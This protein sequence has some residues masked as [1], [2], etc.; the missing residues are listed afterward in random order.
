MPYARQDNLAG[1]ACGLTVAVTAAGGMNET[2]QPPEECCRRYRD[3]HLLLLLIAPSSCNPA[4]IDNHRASKD[5][6]FGDGLPLTVSRLISYVTHGKLKADH[7][8]IQCHVLYCTHG[9]Y[10]H[11]LALLI[12][13]VNVLNAGCTNVQNSDI[14]RTI[15]LLHRRTTVLVSL[16]NG[17]A[18]LLCERRMRYA[19]SIHVAH[20]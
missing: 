15:Y 3:R 2:E 6:S 5:S 8:H 20:W 11:A 18:D 10:V 14:G 13:R 7:L 19:R 12:N 9:L 1:C 17:R 16:A 4:S